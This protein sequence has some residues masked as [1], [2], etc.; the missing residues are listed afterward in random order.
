LRVEVGAGK[1]DI[2][3][4]SALD[5]DLSAVINGGVGSLSVKLPGDMGVRVS[6]DTGIGDLNSSGLTQDGG[7]LVNDAYGVSPNT[8]HLDISAGVGSIE[9]MAP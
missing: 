2:D 4:S 5:H 8:L 9:L 6:V 1:T 3:L 7:Y